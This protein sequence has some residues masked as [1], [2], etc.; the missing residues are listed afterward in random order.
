MFES[1]FA[2]VVSG[3]LILLLAGA[4]T[5][6]KRLLSWRKQPVVPPSELVTHGSY[7]G[8]WIAA[9]KMLNHG[10]IDGGDGPVTIYSADMG[11]S[12]EIIGNRADTI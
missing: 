5:L 2:Q 4:W 1:I 9:G 11:N 6:R 10:T 12:G 3:V 8:I 7:P